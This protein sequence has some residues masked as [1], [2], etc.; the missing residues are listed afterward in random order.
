MWKPSTPQRSHSKQT[1]RAN[2]KWTQQMV[3]QTANLFSIKQLTL[4]FSLD[5]WL[6]SDTSIKCRHFKHELS[7]NV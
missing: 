3:N 1:V 7:Q 5:A 6:R 2:Q 4:I